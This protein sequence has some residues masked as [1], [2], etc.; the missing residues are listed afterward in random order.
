VKFTAF[1]VTISV[2]IIFPLNRASAQGSLTPSGAPAPTMKTLDQIEPRIPINSLPYF[3]T[4]SGSYYLAASLTVGDDHGVVIQAD[5]VTLDL[6][7]F[8]LQGGTGYGIYAP[9]A[10]RNAIIRN[11]IVSG[12][13]GSGVDLA[14]AS[15]CLVEGITSVSNNNMGI[16]IGPESRARN[17]AADLNSSGITAAGPH[18]TVRDCFARRN[19]YNGID[20]GTFVAVEDCEATSNALHGI[21]C[22]YDCQVRRNRCVG[23]GHTGGNGAGIQTA[24]ARNRIENNEAIGNYRGLDIYE[25]PHWILDNVVEKNV[26]NYSISYDPNFTNDIRLLVSELPLTVGRDCFVQITCDITTS[27]GGNGITVEG[28]RVTID[29]GGHM[30]YGPGAG[31]CGIYQDASGKGLT[32]RNGRLDS[33]SS[34][35]QAAIQ[36]GQ[37]ALIEDVRIDNAFNGIR[38]EYNATVRNIQLESCYGRCIWTGEKSLVEDCEIKSGVGE[39]IFVGNDSFV[40]SCRIR[41][42]YFEDHGNALVAGERALV[43]DCIV[44][45]VSSGIVVGAH[46][47]VENCAVSQSIGTGIT[48]AEWCVIRNNRVFLNGSY[49]ASGILLTGGGTLVAGNYVAEN[50]GYGVDGGTNL[51]A[52]YQNVA[53][54]NH[55]GHWNVVAA[56][57]VSQ[58]TTPA[59][60]STNP[61]PNMEY[62]P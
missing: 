6:M 55:H 15:G 12:W 57:G 23:N 21:T 22:S 35:D 32:V 25:S 44:D 54:A 48:A 13:G 20:A 50:G 45:N 34:T 43:T 8:T 61:V 5:N 31:G 29:L 62:S 18:S 7:G 41:T 19:M 27:T 59:S 10:Q 58:F 2:C 30:L 36:A 3:I 42:A 37:Y 33:W 17:C 14:N 39:G 9:N 4:N 46:S 47:T 26:D 11:G 40:K 24:G 38:A 16:S 60:A 52:L 49:G 1:V 53:S 56:N 28:E 51:I